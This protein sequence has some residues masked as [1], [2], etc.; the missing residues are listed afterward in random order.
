MY[1]QIVVVFN[2]NSPPSKR[3]TLK[4]K[5]KYDKFLKQHCGINCFSKV[6][7]LGNLN[8]KKS[9][10]DIFFRIDFSSFSENRVNSP[11]FDN[12]ITKYQSHLSWLNEVQSLL[13][14]LS[15]AK[16]SPNNAHLFLHCKEAQTSQWCW[17]ENERSLNVIIHVKTASYLLNSCTSAE[18]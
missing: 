2:S 16:K 1:L 6:K 8:L 10:N 12:I 5:S 9:P 13:W 15:R 11:T 3:N 18:C 7:S 14:F 17:S 4:V